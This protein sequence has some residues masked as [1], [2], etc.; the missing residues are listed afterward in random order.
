MC[1]QYQDSRKQI[2]MPSNN[3]N[4]KFIYHIL[5]L[6]PDTHLVKGLKYRRMRLETKKYINFH[7][8]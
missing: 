3:I 5:S 8:R 7:S 4:D 1:F 2:H 6:P